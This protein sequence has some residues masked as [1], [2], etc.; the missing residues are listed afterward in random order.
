MHSEIFL[1]C[2]TQVCSHNFIWLLPPPSHL[3]SLGIAQSRSIPV[4][5]YIAAARFVLLKPVWSVDPIA[6]RAF[7]SACLPDIQDLIGLAS[8][9]IP[10]LHCSREYNHFSMPVC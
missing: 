6:A 4:L 2:V 10:E 5:P 7:M 8:A 1:F 9:F 3:S